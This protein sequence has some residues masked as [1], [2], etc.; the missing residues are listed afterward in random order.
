M[1]DT[2]SQIVTL[3][4]NIRELNETNLIPIREQLK[5]VI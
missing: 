2:D 4:I 5:G 3:E 1:T